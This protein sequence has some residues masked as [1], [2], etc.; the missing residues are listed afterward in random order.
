MLA[1]GLFKNHCILVTGGGTGLGRGMAERLLELGAEI[2]ICGRRRSVLDEAGREMTARYGGTVRT[3]PV[4]LRDANGVEAMV[5]KIWAEAP[6]TGLINNAA[7]NFISRTED[8]SPRGFD[9][10]ANTV[11]HGT[12][13]TT[14]AI[15]KR[16][17]RGKI[18]GSVVSIVTT[19]PRTGSPFVVPSAMSKAG[20]DAMTKSLAI[21]WGHYGIRL[22]AVAPGVFP[23]EGATS[24]LRPA[25]NP[26][27]YYKS[28][29]PTG[30]IGELPELTNLVG[31]LLADGCAWLSGETI[32]IDGGHHLADGAY[33]TDYMD[34][35]DA[36]WSEARDRIKAQT[37][38]DKQLR[39]VSADQPKPNTNNAGRARD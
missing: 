20:I 39:T 35:T 27:G 32:A 34:W 3:V 9:A 37:A 23:T 11:F 8:L 1:P 17:I 29:N 10:I 2:W 22:N 16:W 19:W 6:L 38:K 7:G 28:V 4:D 5:E 36:Q 24:A 33:F 18:P 14:L 15:G 13:Y 26:H 31:F 21:E 30:R 12:F 25:D